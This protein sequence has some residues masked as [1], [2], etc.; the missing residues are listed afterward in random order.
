MVGRGAMGVVYKAH[1]TKLKRIVAI[2][3]LAAHLAADGTSRERFVREAQ[4]A[5]AIR[6]THVVGIHAVSDDGSVPYLVMELIDGLTLERQIKAKGPPTVKEI[7]RIGT[8]AAEGLTAAHR[9][10]VI[11][12]DVKPGQHPSGERRSARQDC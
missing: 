11:H 8:Q 1:D 7:L 12:R 5:A 9:Q 4:A 10:G 3:I 2:K 6:D